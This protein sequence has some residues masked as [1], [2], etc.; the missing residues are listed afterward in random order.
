MTNYLAA[1]TLALLLA[2]GAAAAAPRIEVQGLMPNAAIVTVD[3]ERKL[4]R[5]GD[6]FRGVTLVSANGKSASFEVDGKQVTLGLTHHVGTSYEAPA[7]LSVDIPRD[8]RLQYQTTAR[9]N[10][11]S[12]PVLVDTGANMVAM[13]RREARRLGLDLDKAMETRMETA[14]GL[15]RA[16]R[17]RL[18]SV[19]VGGIVVNNVDAGVVDSEYPS[20]VLL[21]MSYLRHVKFEEKQGIM[22][23][24]RH[25]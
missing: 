25:Q 9:I 8:E 15:V 11:V 18:N 17:V 10:G 24:S 7:L 5:K 22:T 20:T 23:I 19:D 1:G 16:W 14:S 12:V 13:N 3:G 6:E 21:G 2:A 4:M